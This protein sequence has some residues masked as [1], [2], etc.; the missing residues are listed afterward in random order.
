MV[1]ITERSGPVIHVRMQ[2]IIYKIPVWGDELVVEINPHGVI[3]RV[4][5]KV[6]PDL[7]QKTFNRPM[8]A[9]ISEK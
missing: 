8:H 6:H 4:E 1:E 7:A 2:H 5:G 3:E 9:G